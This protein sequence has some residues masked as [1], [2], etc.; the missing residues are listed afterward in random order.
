MVKI[1]EHQYSF[2]S[3]WNRRCRFSN[4]DDQ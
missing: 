2:Q 3:S 1:T 4:G